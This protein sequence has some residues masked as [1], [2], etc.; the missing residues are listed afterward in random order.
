M[1]D[2][3]YS[4]RL[5]A[6][7][8]FSNTFRNF[9]DVSD[10]VRQ[11]VRDQQKELRDL[12]RAA[13]NVDGYDRLQ[14]K[15]AETS[16]ELGSARTEQARLARE[17]RET[18]NPSKR[19][20]NAYDRA[21]AKVKTLESAERGH[22]VELDRVSRNLTE[23]GVDTSN[24]ADEQRR[25]ERSIESANGA[26]K[27]QRGR[28][29]AVR[30]AQGRIDANRQ[31]R[32][33]LRGRAIETAALGYLA[34]RPLDR[35][36]DVQTAAAEYAKVANGAS[37][38]QVQGMASANLKMATERQFAAARLNAVDL[39]RIQASAAQGGVS[40]EEIM[41]F[42]RTA[43]TMAAAFDMTADDAGQTLM[44]WRAG[45]GLD[46][47]RA[48]TLADASNVLGNQLNA[49][50]GDIAD[51]LRRQGAV[52]MSSGFD[53]LQ[54]AAL[55]AALL[56]GGA[57][58]EVSATALKNLTGALTKGDAATGRQKDAM[59]SLGFSATGLAS[60]MQSDAAGTTLRVIEAL[61]NA[62]PEKT[63]A[64][65]TQLF[66][67]ESKGA[68]MPLLA[69]TDALRDAFA[70]VADE[71]ALAGSMSEE[72]AGLAATSRTSWN[73]LT[74]SF[75]RLTALVGTAMLPAF[76]A[77]ANPL[78]DA[79]NLVADF[80]EENQGLVGVLAAGAAGLVAIKTAALGL[81]Y[82][83]LMLGQGANF[84]RLARAKSGLNTRQAQTAQAA[85]GATRRLNM[86]MN[87]LGRGRGGAA[88]AAGR[89]R[90][91]GAGLSGAG[92]A[93]VG[94]AAG[95]WR[96]RLSRVGGWA[97]RMGNS[98]VGRVAGRA[99]LPLML[100]GGASQAA[101]AAGEGDAVG[102]GNAVGGMAGGMGGAWAGAGAGAALGTM[103]MPGVG[104][105]VGGAA[106]GLI[107]GIAGSEA[108]Q[109]IGEKAGSLWDWMTGDDKP[110]K[111]S[112]D[113]IKSGNRVASPNQV[114][115]DIARGS[116]N[117]TVAPKFDIKIESTGDQDK[118]E[119]LLDRLMERLRGEMVPMLAGDGL[120]VRLDASLTDGGSR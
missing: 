59:S 53:E 74:S 11:A 119:A 89:G 63:S 110:A 68:I 76:E 81:Q 61:Q 25:L 55:S 100:L 84:A 32:A 83:K 62:P 73:R 24:L 67:E 27:S 91:R 120:D 51:V 28:L 16:G 33:D 114:A 116:D 80:A 17:M 54:T 95:G 71:Q 37:P 13:K 101:N 42:T 79:V 113:A 111:V 47:Q 44:A 106:G 102:V 14:R 38:E 39:F 29:D 10:D 36:M 82:G 66:G 90:Y 107:G 105:A 57:S 104:T 12:N 41:P 43:A 9:E 40:S 85:A 18:E 98:R 6:Q 4:I 45:M 77:V 48:T 86:T 19:L 64:L 2:A 87:M 50:S 22:R 31:A 60:S 30:D 115:R 94:N 35:A 88:G 15:L 96:G 92:A 78:A 56:N 1:A 109:W 103:I 46:Q 8:A 65:V 5:A 97:N 75:G 99:A 7:D 26:L 72:A 21:T 20:A 70:M 34:S 69:N 58:R 52:A 3:K 112:P 108:G 23:A 118:D 93:A 117:R 49:E